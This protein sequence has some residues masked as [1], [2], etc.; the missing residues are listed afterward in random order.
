MQRKENEEV[1]TTF[2]YSS[3]LEGF[4]I[5]HLGSHFFFSLFKLGGN[6]EGKRVIRFGLIEMCLLIDQTLF[7]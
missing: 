6:L 5:F 2:S 7:F 4:G 1:K 3:I